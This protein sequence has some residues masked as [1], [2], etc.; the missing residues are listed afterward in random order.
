MISKSLQIN[1]VKLVYHVKQYKN[2]CMNYCVLFFLSS[3]R[4]QEKFRKSR[5]LI[6]AGCGWKFFD[7]ACEPG[8]ICFKTL[9]FFSCGKIKMLFTRLGRSV[10][11]RTVHSV[12]SKTLGTVFPIRTVPH[13][14]CMYAFCLLP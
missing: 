2:L 11:G 9:A 7:L 14:F 8:R 10:S 12:L 6:G 1:T 13:I 3:I 4:N 5:N